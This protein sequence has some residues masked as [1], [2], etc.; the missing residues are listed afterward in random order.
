MKPQTVTADDFWHISMNIQ[1]GLRCGAESAASKNKLTAVDARKYVWSGENTQ[2]GMRALC[3]YS[4]DRIA[5]RSGA[6]ALPSARSGAGTHWVPWPM[7]GVCR[8]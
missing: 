3:P 7:S 2:N 6:S 8:N 5:V 4:H 1:E